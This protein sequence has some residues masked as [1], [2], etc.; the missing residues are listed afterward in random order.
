MDLIPIYEGA[1]LELT[2]QQKALIPVRTEPVAFREV[3]REIRTVGILDYN[4]TR[5]GLRFDTNFWVD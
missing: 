2:E 4:E 5:D 1:G 3:S